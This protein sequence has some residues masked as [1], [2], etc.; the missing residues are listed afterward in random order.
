ML[1]MKTILSTLLLA[2]AFVVAGCGS[3][4][5]TATAPETDA[6]KSHDKNAMK[7]P[8]PDAMKAPSDFKSSLNGAGPGGAAGGGATPGP[9]GK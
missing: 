6:F 3:S 7:P 9:G 5:D 1:P 4:S 8:P 2:V